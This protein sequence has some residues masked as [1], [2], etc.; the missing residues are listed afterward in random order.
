MECT[1]VE[2]NAAITEYISLQLQPTIMKFKSKNNQGKKGLDIRLN[3]NQKK[4]EIN[5][6]RSATVCL[7]ILPFSPLFT[8]SSVILIRTYSWDLLLFRFSQY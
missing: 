6:E 7:H 8:V 3:K 1:T 2:A 5:F 4:K